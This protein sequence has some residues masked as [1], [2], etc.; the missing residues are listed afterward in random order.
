MYLSRIGVPL[1]DRKIQRLLSNPYELHQAI[2]LAFPHRSEGGAGRVLYRVEPEVTDGVGTLLVQS[3][4]APK[5]NS[6]A[7]VETLPRVALDWKEVDFGLH[8]GLRLR[9]R[10][11]FNPTVTRS[12]TRHPLV[13]EDSQR[14][15]LVE[16]LRG[17]RRLVKSGRPIERLQGG[18]RLEGAVLVDEGKVTGRR[19]HSEA[20]K[21]M[22]FLSVRA[23]GVVTVED[24]GKA[25]RA[26][27]EGLGPAK[28]FGFGLLSLARL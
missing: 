7:T 24:S 22:T 12:G 13:G 23:D 5:W 17:E 3:E 14:R 19:R 16:C 18:F 4:G 28:A 27:R 25:L 8:L 9:F 15:W 2:L 1:A 10:L 21:P 6:A 11:R 20:E 26:I